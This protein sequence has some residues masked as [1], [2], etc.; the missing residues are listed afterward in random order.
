MLADN[1]PLIQLRIYCW[2]QGR[3]RAIDWDQY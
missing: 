3:E 2:G 1:N